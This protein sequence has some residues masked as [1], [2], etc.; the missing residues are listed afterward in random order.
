[1]LVIDASALVEVLTADPDDRPSLALRVRDVEWM[2]APDLIDYEVLNVLRKL[3]QR[4]DIDTAVAELSREALRELR[5]IRHAMTD[6]AAERIWQLRH[7]VSAYDAAYVTLAERLNFPLV[8]TERRLVAAT[9][10]IN[11][12]VVEGH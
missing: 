8:T 11:T 3:L 9:A 5:I 1:M 7:N 10:T 4:G 12:V 2:V 6:E